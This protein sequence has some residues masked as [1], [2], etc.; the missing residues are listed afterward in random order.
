MSLLDQWFKN[1]KLEQKRNQFL[2]HRMEMMIRNS[3]VSRETRLDLLNQLAMIS[4]DPDCAKRVW[5]ILNFLLNTLESRESE[6]I[7]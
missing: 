1:Q 3:T 6:A 4:S 7:W 5:P 2:E